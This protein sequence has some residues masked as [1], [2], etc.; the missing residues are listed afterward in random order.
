M[1]TVATVIAMVLGSA[2]CVAGVL[3]VSAKLGTDRALRAANR[4]L[5]GKAAASAVGF[6]LL[7]MV[8]F[9][10]ISM[11]WMAIPAGWYG[12]TLMGALSVGSFALAFAPS[13]AAA[14]SHDARAQAH[15]D[16]R[17]AA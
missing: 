3:L 11:G 5:H 17:R 2:A 4:K 6:G 10:A 1:N 7:G 15:A 13:G 16:A 12:V 14:A 8:V 9:A